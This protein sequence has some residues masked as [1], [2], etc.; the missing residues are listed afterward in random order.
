LNFGIFGG[1]T[2]F[3]RWLANSLPYFEQLSFLEHLNPGSL[4]IVMVVWSFFVLNFWNPPSM[5][6]LYNI[7]TLPSNIYLI[8]MLINNLGQK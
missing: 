6:N 1:P 8:K 2:A 7:R 5:I 3:G 4:L